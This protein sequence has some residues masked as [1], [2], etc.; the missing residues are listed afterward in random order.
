[1]SSFFSSFSF[2]LLLLLSS[3]LTNS[4]PTVSKDVITFT[5]S[6]NTYTL[7]KGP[8]ASAYDQAKDICSS[9]DGADLATVDNL[10]VRKQIVDYF[11]KNNVILDGANL[12]VSGGKVLNLN[13]TLMKVNDL[14]TE[15]NEFLCE[16]NYKYSDI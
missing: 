1:M 14:L 13:Y 10:V 11:I 3:P 15:K 4:A 8:Y 6:S 9:I 5:I 7:F 16:K 12:F 2:L